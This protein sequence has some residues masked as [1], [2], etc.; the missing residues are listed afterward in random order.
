MSEIKVDTVA[1][2]T[3]ANGVTVD[4][5]NIK[6][7]KLVTANSVVTSNVT[8]GN[9]TTAKILDDNVTYAKIQNVSATDRILGRDSSGAGVI[10]EIT[11]AN[12]R[13]MINVADG[14]TAGGGSWNLLSTTTIDDDASVSI[15]GLD[16]TYK[17]YAMQLINIDTANNG[18][19]LR[20]R[21]VIGGSVITT[22]SYDF[23]QD[24]TKAAPSDGSGTQ[25]GNDTQEIELTADQNMGNSANEHFCSTIML[26]NPSET[27]YRKFITFHN[28]YYQESDSFCQVVG[29]G[30]FN[31]NSSAL[32]GLNFLTNSGNL[33]T[34]TI[35]LYGIT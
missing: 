24:R 25:T 6:D 10:E 14:A 5:L 28:I 16:S 13:T 9:I 31:G 27:S 12:L 30:T 7:S 1:E 32:Q 26:Y 34:G 20:C 21:F 22:G 23:V 29:G 3:S 4:G 18:P 17:V 35:K 8:D 33:K 11:P 19:L 15:T 2:K